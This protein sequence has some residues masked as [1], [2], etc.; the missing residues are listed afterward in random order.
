MQDPE[1]PSKGVRQ[2]AA[3]MF[4]D[5]AGYTAMM[6]EDEKTAKILRDRQRTTLERLIPTHN[7]K[8]I[9]YFGDGTLSIFGSAIDAVRCSIDIQEELRKEPKVSLRIG[10]HSGDIVLD[11]DGV[12]GDCVNLASRIEA[13]SVPGAALVSDKV[14]DEIKNQKDIFTKYLGKFNLKN[15]KR[16]V[17]VYAIANEGLAIPT[18]AQTG[19]KAG[20]EHSIAVLP[21]VNMSADPEN[22]YFSD[23]IS[24]EILNGLTHVDG[25]QV[26][27][28]TSSFSFKGKSQDVRHIGTQLGVST[29]LE[30]SVRRSGK[31]MRITAQ[32]IN[33][34]DGY[35][36][37]SEVYDSEVEDIFQVQDEISMKIVN[38]LKENFN[39]TKKTEPIIKAPTE[40]IE[41]Y[42]LYLKGRYYWNK[43]TPEY[44]RKAIETFEEVIKIDPAFALAY[45]SLSYCYSFMGST[46]L[47][48]P[49]EAYPRAKDLTLHAIGLDPNLA[50]SHLSLATI[51]FFHNWDF[52]GAESALHKAL[53]LSLNSSLINQVHGWFLIAKGDFTK[54]IEKMEQAVS[55]DPLSLPL[56]S[57]LA[58][59]YSFAQRFSEALAQYDRIVEMDPTY[60]R[61]FEGRG[62]IY[63]AR[64][65]YEKAIP[66]FE[67]YHNLIGNP[68]K[69]V[70]SLGHA[71]AMSGQMDKALDCLD[72]LKQREAAEPDT[73][74]HMDYAFLYTG[75][76]DFDKAF[77]HLNK[78]YEQ[79][80][81]IACLGMIFCVRYP[82]LNELRSDPRFKDL[83]VRMGMNQ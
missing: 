65:E 26:T 77:Y 2:L 23:G 62:M 48:P 52:D 36:L 34:S 18:A 61:A 46:G 58:D 30:G 47:M 39:P 40:N 51:K 25:L 10:L 55:L 1:F 7:G 35:H 81:G 9:Q 74:L 50:E 11:T 67:Q 29:V 4:A 78:T 56:M 6:Q 21:F 31:R 38:R 53:S 44:I 45:T 83:T 54:A 27:A 17:E 22:E 12:Y 43:S 8:I 19:V 16:K 20:A 59:A 64:G 69:G 76:R 75:L 63:L 32:L 33:T 49:S 41:A 60:R 14:F 66:D 71:Y 37:W 70:S 5:M 73:I 24:E 82:M 79:R 3:I 28:R 57:N 15:V 68:L 72:R 42:N 13:L 80:I